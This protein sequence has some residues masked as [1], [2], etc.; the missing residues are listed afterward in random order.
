MSK[1]GLKVEENFLKK[2]GDEGVSLRL[3]LVNGE[4]MTGVVS[5]VGRY[6]VN[7]EYEGKTVTLPKKDIFHISPASQVLDDSFFQEGRDEGILL[8]VKTK[9]QDEFLDRFVKE[10]TLALCSMMNGEEIRGVLQG[11]DGFTLALK[12]GRGQLLLYKHGLSSI[13]PGYRRRTVKEDAA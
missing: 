12:T 10:K 6:D 5:L 11:Y 9:V 7:V 4:R 1:Q 13:G 8:P 2:A 3:S